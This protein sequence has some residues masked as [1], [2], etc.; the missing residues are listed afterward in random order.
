MRSKVEI[1][2]VAVAVVVLTVALASSA[3]S[4]QTTGC[5]NDPLRRRLSLGDA[6]MLLADSGDVYQSTRSMAGVAQIPRAA[7]VEVVDSVV[8]ARV[9]T[10]LRADRIA[11]NPAAAAIAAT[12]A[13]SI[14][15][16]R[17]G[18]FYVVYDL[19]MRCC[20]IIV[21]TALTQVLGGIR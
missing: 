5:G 2:R 14:Y 6:R 3:I 1:F 13:D 8:C 11:R 17:G 15:V 12:R 19:K 18:A 16:A 7:V 21:D 4:Q 9:S 20:T 10:F